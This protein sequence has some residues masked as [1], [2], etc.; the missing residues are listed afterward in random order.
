VT[1]FD[2]GCVE[3]EEEKEEREKGGAL[4]ELVSSKFLLA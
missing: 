1:L 2:T 4:A 3:E